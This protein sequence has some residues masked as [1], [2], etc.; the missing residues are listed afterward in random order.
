MKLKRW[1]PFMAVILL[2]LVYVI[3]SHAGKMTAGVSVKAGKDKPVVVLDAGHGGNDPGK[4]GIDGTLE[5][6]INL[7]ITNRLKKYL[8][9]SDVEVVLTRK[10]DNGLY[11]DRDSRKKMA[12]MTKR[13]E[14]INDANPALTV[15]IHQNSYHQ[16]EISG[17]QVFY[18]K[19][20]DKG[21]RLAEI[22][23]ERFDYVLGEKNTRLAKPNDNYYLL[24]HVKSPIVIV[25]CGFLT[26][27][28]EAASLNSEEYQD[29][30][31]W[32]IH[33]GIMEYLNGR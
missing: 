4:I 17:G 26:N 23:Q 32:T 2:V 12:D 1:E 10:N 29:R 31:A 13:C 6:D 16:E 15:S 9:A 25:E 5:K 7:Q 11:T 28:K 21:K 20:S 18:Y 19:K 8:E 24:L 3:S 33:M 30:V 14:I 22:I 27:W